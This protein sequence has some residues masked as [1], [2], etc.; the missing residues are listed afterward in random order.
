M[1]ETELWHKE[2]MPFFCKPEESGGLGCRE[3]GLGGGADFRKNI[4]AA[5]EEM[6]H[7]IVCD[8]VTLQN[9]RPDISSFLDGIFIGYMELKSV[10][11]GQTAR[12]QGRGKV[13][14]DDLESVK[15]V[16]ERAKAHPAARDDR[17]E[18]L[19]MFEKGVHLAATG[20]ER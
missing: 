15:G 14:G 2:I 19:W 12:V 10:T 8:G 16:A 11:N 6:K 20:A 3:T 13:I 4:F 17:R 7:K 9:L 18:T 1:I 5:V